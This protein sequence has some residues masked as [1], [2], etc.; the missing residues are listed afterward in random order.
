MFQYIFLNLIFLFFLFL[1]N[2]KLKSNKSK[3]N[4]LTIWQTTHYNVVTTYYVASH[5]SKY[6]LSKATN[7]ILGKKFKFFF[8]VGGWL[9][10][11]IVLSGVW[12]ERPLYEPFE[13]ERK[14]IV[15]QV[16][17]LEYDLFRYS[18]PGCIPLY[19]FVYLKW[20]EN[21]FLKKNNYLP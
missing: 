4:Y 13:R 6:K 17:W 12:T 3:S 18:I 9:S 11:D 10:W 1:Y 8:I 7:L 21:Y 5:S 15:D 2:T 19:T 14:V 16:K 20:N